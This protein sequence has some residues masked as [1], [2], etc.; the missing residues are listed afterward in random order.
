MGGRKKEVVSLY[1]F[2]GMGRA[3][4]ELVVEKMS[5]YEG[6]FVNLLVTEELGSPPPEDD[7]LTLMTDATVMSLSYVGFGSIPLL[8]YCLGDATSQYVSRDASSLRVASAM[9]TSLTL[10]GLG[11]A[12]STFSSSSWFYS[13]VEAV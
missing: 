9:V 5:H 10:F 6:F 7:E 11:G 1:E 2:R 13:G 12:K 4:A 8:V 3:D